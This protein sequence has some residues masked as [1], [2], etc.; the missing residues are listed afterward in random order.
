ML[1]S[2]PAVMQPLPLAGPQLYNHLDD[3]YMVNDPNAPY[4]AE[5]RRL[6]AHRHTPEAIDKLNNATRSFSK[7]LFIGSPS[8]FMDCGAGPRGVNAYIRVRTLMQGGF[9]G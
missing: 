5:M 9:L 6:A 7:V 1:T 2:Q 3:R 4:I 8:G